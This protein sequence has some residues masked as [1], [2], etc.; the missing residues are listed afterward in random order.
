MQ[1]T[2]SQGYSLVHTK[3]KT[4]RYIITIQGRSYTKQFAHQLELDSFVH[5]LVA[6]TQST[7]N[8]KLV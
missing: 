2:D 4:M 8:I 3:G 5:M 7:V 6:T 1:N